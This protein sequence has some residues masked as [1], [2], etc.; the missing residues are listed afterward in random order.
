MPSMY[1]I[2]ITLPY[3]STIIMPTNH[4][5]FHLSLFNLAFSSFFL[6]SPTYLEQ[7]QT[8]VQRT[9]A[10]QVAVVQNIP[11]VPMHENL[12]W[13]NVQGLCLNYETIAASYP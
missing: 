4:N 8:P 10:T 12:F 5:V 1:F 6:D 11:Q 7:V 2:C 9:L 13:Q 3:Q